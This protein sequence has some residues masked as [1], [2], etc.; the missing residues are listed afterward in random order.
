MNFPTNVSRRTALRLLAVGAASTAMPTLVS[1]S[2]DRPLELIVPVQPGGSS[3]VI[4]RIIGNSVTE[5][6]SRAVVIVN[7]GGVFGRLGADALIDARPDGNTIGIL[8]GSTSL[9]PLIFENSKRPY[10]PGVD[11][12][13]ITLVGRSPSFIAVNVN[14]VPAKTGAE[15]LSFLKE[16][17]EKFSYGHGGNGSSPALATGALL[18]RLGLTGISVPYKGWGPVSVALGREEV[19]FGLIDYGTIRPQLERGAVRLIAIM[20]EQRSALMPDIPTAV[21][22]GL[23]DAANG[24]TPWFFLAAPPGTPKAV[25]Q[26]LNKDFTQALQTPD[27]MER[28]RS[29]GSDPNS[30]TPESTSAEYVAFR[31]KMTDV[32]KLLGIS[33]KA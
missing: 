33:M 15:F 4:A 1:A 2:T 11:F 32:I 14:R 9:F 21:E 8:Y 5:L 3:D 22:A 16:N 12:E 29:I 19:D 26:A 24:I 23:P 25:V 10:E 7:K 28:I 30:S 27:V 31:K 18:N 6:T 17:N 13:P 20:E